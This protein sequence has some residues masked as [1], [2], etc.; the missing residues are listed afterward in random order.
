MVYHYQAR[1]PARSLALLIL[2]SGWAAFA[3]GGSVS[4]AHASALYDFSNVFLLVGSRL[5]Q[6]LQNYSARGTGQL[7]SV[8][9]GMN[10]CGAAAR[11]F[12]TLT[13]GGGGAM[14][15]G[16]F[17]SEWLGGIGNWGREE[18]WQVPALACLP[19]SLTQHTHFPPPTCRPHPQLHHRRSNPVLFFRQEE[20]GGQGARQGRRQEE[21]LSSTH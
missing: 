3:A 12:T 8:T 13:E 21:G 2:L 6:I 20:G 18:R 4:A 16:A 11:I 17:L 9:Y 15:R 10:T 19:P 1:S 7:S 5:P 14:L